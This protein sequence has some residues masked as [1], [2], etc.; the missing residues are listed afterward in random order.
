VIVLELKFQ[1]YNPFQLSSCFVYSVKYRPVFILGVHNPRCFKYKPDAL[2]D[3]DMP[4]ICLGISMPDTANH[5]MTTMLLEV[6]VNLGYSCQ[7]SN[8]C[9]N[10]QTLLS[11]FFGFRF[12]ETGF[13]HV[14]L[15]VWNSLCSPGWPQTQR[16][17]CHDYLKKIKNNNNP[18]PPPLKT[19]NARTACFLAWLPQSLSFVL[20]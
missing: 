1:V 14:A 19:V 2:R 7:S 10:T 8:W 9:S 4:H 12:S 20:F 13:L 5:T 3:C 6:C 17:A 11:F 18:P 15:T 16:L